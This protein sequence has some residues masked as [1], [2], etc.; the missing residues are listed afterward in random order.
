MAFSWRQHH[1]PSAHLFV[2]QMLGYELVTQSGQNEMGKQEAELDGM[3]LAHPVALLVPASLQPFFHHSLLLF[4][5][6]KS[7]QKSSLHSPHAVQ[8]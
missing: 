6:S 5:G 2:K 3:N 1:F 4:S 8:K 7:P